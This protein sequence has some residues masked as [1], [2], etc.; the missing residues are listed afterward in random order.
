MTHALRN[1]SIVLLVLACGPALAQEK[2][3]AVANVLII[4]DSVYHQHARGT[5]NEL[6]DQANVQFANWPK[7]VL[8]N[9]TNAI[10]HL[11]LLLGLRD[12]AG[13]EVPEGKRPTWDLIHFNVGL[14]DL[15]YCVPKFKS[16]RVQPHHAGGVIR[17]DAE[18]YQKNLE[19]LVRLLRQ[20]APNAK[21]VWANTTPI[22]H[23]REN[24]FKLGTEVEYNRIAE[25]VMTKHSVPVNDMYSYAISIMNMDKPASHGVDP[26][27]FDSK[28]IHPPIVNIIV[29]E[30]N[31]PIKKQVERANQA[32]KS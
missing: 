19:T 31:I 20:K 18:Q 10:E 25:Q 5:I 27:H 24:L 4:G 26:F 15:I 29:R 23:S 28:P 32:A 9:S 30:L 13:K 11:D 1:M 2:K 22:R 12:A 14:G 7:G 8:P 16:H 21:L 17:T 6:K 3:P